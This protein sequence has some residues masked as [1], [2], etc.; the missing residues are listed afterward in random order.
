MKI[1]PYLFIG[2][3]LSIEIVIMII[4]VLIVK[5]GM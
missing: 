5:G 4:Y 2:G 3:T 1:N